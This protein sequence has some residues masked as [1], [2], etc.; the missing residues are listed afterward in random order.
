M[1]DTQFKGV[2]KQFDDLK[3][4]FNIK[5]HDSE[6]GKILI[7]SDDEL[8]ESFNSN[9]EKYDTRIENRLSCNNYHFYKY[10][11]KS[12]WLCTSMSSFWL[13]S[14]LSRRFS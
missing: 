2:Y 1:L 13:L 6:L 10:L 3:V 4:V 7:P 12:Q 11:S 9:N 8:A 5:V 14:L